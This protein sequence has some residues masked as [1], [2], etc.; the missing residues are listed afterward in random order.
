MN[1]INKNISNLSWLLGIKI[2]RILISIFI[3][4]W[5]AKYLGP[6]EYGLFNY[7]LSLIVLIS[8]FSSLGLEQIF[9]KQLLE[10]NLDENLLL[11]STFSLKLIGSLI[12]IVLSL[13]I[14]LVKD[15]NGTFIMLV[16]FISLS[17]IFKAFEVIRFWF[18]ANLLS[19]ESSK[20]D[21]YAMI[22][23]SIFKISLILF[24]AGVIWFGV[25][26]LFEAAVLAIGL[27]Y[28][29]KKHHSLKLWKVYYPLMKD[30]LVNAWP[31]ILAGAMYTIFTRIDQIMLGDLQDISTVGIYVS[32]VVLSQGWL[33]LPAIIAKAFYPQMITSKS[34]NRDN[35][36]K[37]TQHLLNIISFIAIFISIIIT[38]FSHDII[39]YT[40]GESYILAAPILALHVWGGVFT[41]MSAISYKYFIAENLQ[42]TSFYRGLVGLIINIILNIILIPIY[43]GYGAAIATVISLVASLYLFNVLTKSTREM[44]FMQTKAILLFNSFNSFK[45]VF[46]LV[47][48]R[49]KK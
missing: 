37:T 34:E 15:E 36:L 24:N 9:V 16:S 28:I 12:L 19:K 45:Y 40:F 7:V 11:G 23:T 49:N 27:I 25:S 48:T 14:V 22:L 5:I 44:F 32:A 46:K 29:Y 30:L 2:T 6:S 43:A 4:I 31:L 8:I 3:S 17:Y 39:F 42:K 38:I 1:K 20:I 13:I 33:F 41:A 21:L 18:E 10:K 47:T 35:Y 26:V